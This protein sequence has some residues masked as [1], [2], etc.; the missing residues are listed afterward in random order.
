VFGLGL[1]L[2]RFALLGFVQPAFASTP[3]AAAAQAAW[4]R[5]AR[6]LAVT[7]LPL[8]GIG[9]VLGVAS[10]VD[11]LVLLAAVGWLVLF[12]LGLPLLLGRWWTGRVTTPRAVSGIA[13]LFALPHAA[14]GMALAVSG[15][16]GGAWLAVWIGMGAIFLIVSAAVADLILRALEGDRPRPKAPS[17]MAESSHDRARGPIA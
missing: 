10:G 16:L 3:D 6:P 14:I 1:L 8:V 12:F 15:G 4:R 13:L 7:G 5:R 11:P 17:E 9:L 2:L